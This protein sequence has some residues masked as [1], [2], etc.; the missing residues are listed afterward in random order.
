M[1]AEEG[2][3]VNPSRDPSTAL[4]ITK[5]PSMWTGFL[6]LGR[7]D[8]FQDGF[9]DGGVILGKEG[10]NLAVHF[11]VGLFQ[12][13]DETAVGKAERAD[14]RVDADG[15]QAAHF[16]LLAAAVLKGVGASLEEGGAS[17]FNLGLA[18]PHHPLGLLQQVAA[19]FDVLYA[20]FYAWHRKCT[21]REL[22]GVEQRLDGLGVRFRQR[23]VA[24]LF[25]RDLAGVAGVEVGLAGAA[26]H[27][28]AGL[29]DA[30]ALGEGL[31]GLEL[32][33][34]IHQ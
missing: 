1:E 18:T 6:L 16:T 2:S 19:A 14:G 26:L 23:L 27:D 4:G 29:G 9:E 33:K 24:A 15:P 17:Q 31:V 20:A 22:R 28:L 13:V 32:H 10:K 25:A 12:G 3:Y 8:L 7:R 21:G 11:Y 5:I 34:G 30:N